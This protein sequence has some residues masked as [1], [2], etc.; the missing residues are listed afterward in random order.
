MVYFYTK[1]TNLGMFWRAFEWKMLVY[2]I[3]FWYILLSFVTFYVHLFILWSIGTF[4]TVLV[5]CTKKNL[6][7][8]L[9]SGKRHDLSKRPFSKWH[10]LSVTGFAE[11]SPFGGKNAYSN[12]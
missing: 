12:L 9:E 6:A 3:P 11:I 4:Q 8:L 7:T 1:N 5:C 10:S 2:F